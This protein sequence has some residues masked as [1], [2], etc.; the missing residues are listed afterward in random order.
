MPVLPPQM[1]KYTLGAR[2]SLPCSQGWHYD[3]CVTLSRTSRNQY[4]NTIRTYAK[5][6]Q[7][8]ALTQTVQP[9]GQVGATMLGR[10]CV[11]PNHAAFELKR[12][13]VLAACRTWGVDSEN[14]PQRGQFLPD[15]QAN[16][17]EDGEKC[18]A[19]VG[20]QP[21]IFKSDRLLATCNDTVRPK[22]T[23]QCGSC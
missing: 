21:M 17:Q 15:S 5:L 7:L 10:F 9:D 14:R 11:S 20:F 16:S 1:M 4:S 19:A 23:N 2:A 18:T 12:R 6:S 13:T 8:G 22:R 3:F